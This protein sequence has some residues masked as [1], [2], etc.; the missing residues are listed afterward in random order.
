M[1]DKKTRPE[2][3]E[4]AYEDALF[5]LLVD[6]VMESKGEKYIEENE[7]LRNDPTFVLPE[8]MDE[9]CLGEIRQHSQKEKRAQNL[10]RFRRIAVRA[11]IVVCVVLIMFSIP[12]FSSS[13]VR[14][15]SLDRIVKIFGRETVITVENNADNVDPVSVYKSPSWFPAGAWRVVFVADE[16]NMYVIRYEDADSNV[17]QYSEVPVNGA[18]LTM[19]TEDSGIRTD[20]LIDNFK[21]VMASK[22]GLVI[23]SWIDDNRDLICTLVLEGPE[24]IATEDN[25]IKIAESIK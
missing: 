23:I 10:R 2:N 8:Q 15:A 7:Q 4:S 19:D 6:K 5:S 21:A 18:A 9:R 24:E 22:A 3:L 25:A 13:A 11:A 1:N 14:T 16:E 12:F 17:I 20:F